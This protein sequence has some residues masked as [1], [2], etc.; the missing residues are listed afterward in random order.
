LGEKSWVTR[1]EYCE[2]RLG[3][4]TF[5]LMTP[6]GPMALTMAA[7]FCSRWEAEVM[8]L[9]CPAVTDGTGEMALVD[10]AGL[11]RA[12]AREVVLALK[13]ASRTMKFASP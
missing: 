7:V 3:V 8:K 4:R 5:S 1:T 6:L 10:A 11:G 12:D 9:V 2:L 13:V